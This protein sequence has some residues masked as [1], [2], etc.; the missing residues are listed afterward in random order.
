MRTTT[1][2][3]IIAGVVILAVALWLATVMPIRSVVMHDTVGTADYSVTLHLNLW[4]T[5]VRKSIVSRYR[6]KDGTTYEVR[7][8]GKT[9]GIMNNHGPWTRSEQSNDGGWTVEPRWYIDGKAATE[10]E[11]NDYCRRR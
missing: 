8:E 7:E 5:P 4:G 6:L 3:L 10:Q 9:S 1:L 11:W 2:A